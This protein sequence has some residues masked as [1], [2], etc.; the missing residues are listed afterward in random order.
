MAKKKPS[1]GCDSNHPRGPVDPKSFRI[2][3][4]PRRSMPGAKVKPI[5]RGYQCG[6]CQDGAG[7]VFNGPWIHKVGTRTCSMMIPIR[8]SP[9]GTITWK[10]IEWTEQCTGSL[11][12]DPWA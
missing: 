7:L 4:V 8:I 1:C 12:N 9:S 10:R 3:D 11:V 2:V 5:P 6:E